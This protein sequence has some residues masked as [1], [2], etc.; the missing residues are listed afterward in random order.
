MGDPLQKWLLPLVLFLAPLPASKLVCHSLLDMNE[1]VEP[2]PPVL[3][4]GS[5]LEERKEGELKGPT[6]PTGGAIRN[7]LALLVVR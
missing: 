6:K 3:H 2:N 1:V 7:G 4:G 5:R